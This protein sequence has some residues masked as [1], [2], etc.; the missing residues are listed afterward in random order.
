MAL[1]DAH[2]LL[3]NPHLALVLSI[4]TNMSNTGTPY[5]IAPLPS[6]LNLN[7]IGELNNNDPTISID[8]IMNR[9]PPIAN[10][11]SPTTTIH[12]IQLPI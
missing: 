11:D 12:H 9:D 7:Q 5:L 6:L 2:L 4:Y 8:F 10:H 3:A 1:D